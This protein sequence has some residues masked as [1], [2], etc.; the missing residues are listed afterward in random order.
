MTQR[1]LTLAEK[2]ELNAKRLREAISK[3]CDVNALRTYA[4]QGIHVGTSTKTADIPQELQG[5]LD[6]LQALLT[7]EKKTQVASPHDI[8]ALLMVQLGDLNHEEFH[9]V[10]LDGKHQV[11]AIHHL[12]TGSLNASVVRVSEVFRTALLL[13]SLS[14]IIVHNHPSGNPTP[15]QEDI[16]VTRVIAEMGDKLDIPLVDHVIIGKGQ[17][18]SLKSNGYF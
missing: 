17:W 1:Y 12:Y 4:A 14:I 2:R 15:S 16:D 10:C 8:A 18:T 6:L 11:Q 13:N 7:P 3:Y 9:V 5:V